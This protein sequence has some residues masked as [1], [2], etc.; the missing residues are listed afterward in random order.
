MIIVKEYACTIGN[1]GYSRATDEEVKLWSIEYKLIEECDIH[2]VEQR[3][4]Y[5]G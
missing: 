3:G 5:S 2:N 1:L 4:I